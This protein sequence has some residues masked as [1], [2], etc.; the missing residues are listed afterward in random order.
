VTIVVTAVGLTLVGLTLIDAFVTTLAVGSGAG[1]VSS[2]VTSC[3]WRVLR[4]VGRRTASGAVLPLSGVLTVATTFM[5]WVLMLWTGWL[6]VFLGGEAVLDSQTRQP[7]GLADRVYYTAFTIFTLGI[8]DYVPGTE[9]AK[10][11][12]S[13]ATLT[14]L[15]LVTSAISY[16]ISVVGAVVQKRALAVQVHGLGRTPEEIVCRGWEGDRFG[17]GLVQ[18]LLAVMPQVAT[19]GESH[20]AYPVLHYFHAEERAKSVAPALAALDDAL[21]LLGSG[22]APLVRPE[23][24]VIEPLRRCN[25]SLLETVTKVFFDRAEHPPPAPS[26]A[27][28]RACGIPTVSDEEFGRA[29]DGYATRRSA[30]LGLMRSD[31]WEWNPD[32]GG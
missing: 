1:P 32:D 31:G 11:A 2:R 10:I 29:L 22:V 30:L 9:W 13:A 18:H 25:D 28:L 6:L 12:T 5:V 15:A 21:M 23:R 26:L 7:G 14:G 8:G 27:K 19:L 20:L 16:V 4:W 17:T 24:A 3:V